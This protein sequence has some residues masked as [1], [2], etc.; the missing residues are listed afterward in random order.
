MDR[1]PFSVCPDYGQFYLEDLGGPHDAPED[2][3][4]EDIFGRR[5]RSNG[6]LIAIYPY[7]PNTLSGEVLIEEDEPRLELDGW[8]HVGECRLNV[9]AGGLALRTPTTAPRPFEMIPLVEGVYW[10]R[11][12]F[13]GLGQYTSDDPDDP[14]RQTLEFV[15]FTLWLPDSHMR[16]LKQWT[17]G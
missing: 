17:G 12:H 6:R 16:V 14:D 5:F 11:I 10:V 13:R 8:D 4:D 15:R 7:D 2:V 3:E 9:V 1:L